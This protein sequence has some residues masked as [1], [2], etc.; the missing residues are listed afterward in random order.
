MI[1]SMPTTGR[2]QQRYDH[3]LQHLVHHTGDVTIATDLGVP[4]STA[5]GW[6]DLAPTVVVCLDVSDLTEPELRQ[7]VVK[8]RR[9][10][11][12]LTA[13]LRLVLA[14][15]RTSGF[16]L[17]EERLPDGRDKMRILRAVDRVRAFVPLRT[18]LRFLRVSPS[19]FHAW[20]R[21][22]QACALDD[23][24]SCPRTSPSRLTP[25]E[26]RAIQDLVTSPD[27]RHVP[28]GTLAVLAQRLGTVWA[29]PST[30]YR[31][32]RQHAGAGPGSACIP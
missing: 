27:Y 17:T 21:R 29:S 14:V 10:V 1:R 8:L 2:P 18:L 24:S 5:R 12:K 30:W 13:L 31:L 11:Q 7:E 20:R 9:R 32:V 3:R 6:L 19:R 15:L 16:R 4:R 26:V 25:S 22:Q 28:T 23:Q